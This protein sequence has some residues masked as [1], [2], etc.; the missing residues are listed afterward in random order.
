MKISWLTWIEA[1][2]GCLGISFSEGWLLRACRG[3]PP[4]HAGRPTGVTPKAGITPPVRTAD[5]A[6]PGG[7]AGMGRGI[8]YRK[9]TQ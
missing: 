1:A 7:A 3:E 5:T 2:L 6:T 8:V 4:M 9:P